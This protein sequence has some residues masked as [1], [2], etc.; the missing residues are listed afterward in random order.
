MEKILTFQSKEFERNVRFA[1]KM[2]DG[3]ITATDALRVTDLC[4][5]DYELPVGDLETLYLFEN[6]Q[7]LVFLTDTDILDFSFF[8]P[9]KKLKALI[10]GG[11]DPSYMH[12]KLVNISA[13]DALPDLKY[14]S[15]ADFN[16]IDLAGIEKIKS[17]E[18]LCIGWGNA[19][20][21]EDRIKEL[22]HLATLELYETHLKDP[23][24]LYK[25][26]ANISL[27]IGG[28]DTEKHLDP[29]LLKKYRELEIL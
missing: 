3:A 25:L 14:L 12:V 20:I 5:D 28:V 8:T 11:A 27:S 13:L 7:E 18:E 21:N 17:L 4:I 1:L 6:L 9:L 15:V 22:P 19:V 2:P 16:E 26:P 10:V 24:F 23:A 29:D